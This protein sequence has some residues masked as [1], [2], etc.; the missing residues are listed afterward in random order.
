M[1]R[2]KNILDK[3]SYIDCSDTINAYHTK[4]YFTIFLSG[5]GI[6][7]A[8]VSTRLRYLPQGRPRSALQRSHSDGH[9]NFSGHW[10]PLLR[11]RIFQKVDEGVL[12]HLGSSTLFI[13]RLTL[14]TLT[15]L[16]SIKVTFLP[17]KVLPDVEIKLPK[18]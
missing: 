15:L 5:G 14:L 11:L 10:R 16:N 13:F 4:K 7:R 1:I 17:R 3:I 2:V 6:F 8:H 18:K 12:R 9:Q